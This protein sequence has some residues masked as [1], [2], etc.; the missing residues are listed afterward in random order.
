MQLQASRDFGDECSHTSPTEG[1]AGTQSNLMD[2]VAVV[3]RTAN[4]SCNS[5]CGHLEAGA[6]DADEQQSVHCEEVYT[7]LYCRKLDYKGCSATHTATHGRTPRQSNQ[8]RD[9]IGNIK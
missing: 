9:A 7:N 1:A 4:I 5:F 3:D 8:E 6:I 2:T